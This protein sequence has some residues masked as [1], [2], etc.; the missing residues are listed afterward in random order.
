MRSPKLET[1]LRS[2]AIL[3]SLRPALD[4][5]YVDLDPTFNLSVDEDF[6]HRLS[7]ISKKS[8]C[9]VYLDWIQYCA[10]R[11]EQVGVLSQNSLSCILKWYAAQ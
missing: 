9:T 6:D 11:R 5:S 7:G 1:W 10:S 3:D 2:E 4:K 8:F